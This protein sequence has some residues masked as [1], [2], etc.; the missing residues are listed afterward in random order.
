MTENPPE[1]KI[2]IHQGLPLVDKSIS[3]P[4]EIELLHYLKNVC[5]V[6]S[7]YYPGSGGDSL[8]KKVFG[9]KCVNGTLSPN[10]SPMILNNSQDIF[11]DYR[12]NPFPNKS[13]DAVY[14][15]C[16][17][18]QTDI[19]EKGALPEISRIVKENGLIVWVDDSMP[20]LQSK[21]L[22]KIR[23][24]GL[25]DITPAKF[26]ELVGKMKF[27]NSKEESGHAIFIFQKQ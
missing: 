1:I 8:P 18:G 10:D 21:Y 24:L 4:R 11:A 14:L 20:S 7:M 19:L 25:K 22:Q 17:A 2:V 15:H 23:E 16:L 12:N 26:S 9:D 3:T 27:A 13:F 5:G 6:K